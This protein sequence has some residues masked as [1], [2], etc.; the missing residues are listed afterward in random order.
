MLIKL[1]SATWS[2][3]LSFSNICVCLHAHLDQMFAW[4]RRNVLLHQPVYKLR[5]ACGSP[6]CKKSGSS[7]EICIQTE[8]S[9]WHTAWNSPTDPE[10]NSQGAASRGESLSVCFQETVCVSMVAE[11]QFIHQ[12][13]T[14]ERMIEV[15]WSSGV[16][17]LPAESAG[18]H[19]TLMWEHRLAPETHEHTTARG[20]P[21][22]PALTCLCLSV[23]KHGLSSVC[24][25]NLTAFFFL[26]NK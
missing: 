17:G 15:W 8:E 25:F 2:H 13:L 24:L 4:S 9:C 12:T 23:V 11:Q 21:E 7:K 5:T 18:P 1:W 26:Q 3:V 19:N 14:Y 22:K 6:E 20:A 10:P 16:W